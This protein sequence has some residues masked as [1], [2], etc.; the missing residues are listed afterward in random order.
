LSVVVFE[1]PAAAA[2][3]HSD[4]VREPIVAAIEPVRSVKQS[5]QAGIPKQAFG[6]AKYFVRL[7][8]QFDKLSEHFIG[9]AVDGVVVWYSWL[10]GIPIRKHWPAGC[11]EPTLVRPEDGQRYQGGRQCG[12]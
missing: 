6:L 9:F 3:E 4:A 10:T 5:G 1:Q 12:G 11:A 7:A 2:A 8:Q